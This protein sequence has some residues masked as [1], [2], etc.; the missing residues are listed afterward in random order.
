MKKKSQA[1]LDTVV[2]Q[3]AN[4]YAGKPVAV[5]FEPL[6]GVLGQATPG[7]D[8]IAVNTKLRALLEALVSGQ[9]KPSTD[10]AEAL[11]TVIHEA[12]HTRAPE[13]KDPATGFGLRDPS[14]GL[15]SWGD[16]WQAHQ[17]AYNLVPDAMQRFFGVP[18]DSAMGDAWYRTAQGRG[19]G[20]S[21][22]GPDAAGVQG[23]GS[24]DR[25]VNRL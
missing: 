19:Y 12:L 22:G 5:G 4:F 3:I 24:P 2:Q 17:L 23:W 14:T 16:E 7:G 25:R 10:T 20:G 9:R 21:L 1:T 11:A 6:Q 15:Y 8:S 13:V 18:A